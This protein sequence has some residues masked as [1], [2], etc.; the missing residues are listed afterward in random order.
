MLQ[1]HMSNHMN[2]NADFVILDVPVFIQTKECS[3]YAE[4]KHVNYLNSEFCVTENNF[5]DFPMY[6]FI[7]LDDFSFKYANNKQDKLEFLKVV[8]YCLRHYKL[9]LVLVI[10]N[11]YS[12]NLSTEIFLSPHIFL[13]YSN[14]GYYIIRY[15]KKL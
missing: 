7:I 1:R 13:A 6:S 10:H 15:H 9:T 11:L 14:L 2:V 8:N 4:I 12:T 5:K 3:D